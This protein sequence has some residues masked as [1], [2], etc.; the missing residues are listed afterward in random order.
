M[1]YCNTLHGLHM[2]KL[3]FKSNSW[4]PIYLFMSFVIIMSGFFSRMLITLRIMFLSRLNKVYKT[5]TRT[6]Q[7]EL[8]NLQLI[9]QEKRT[10][11]KQIW[12]QLTSWMFNLAG[13]QQS[14]WN[15][16]RHAMEIVSYEGF[17]LN[18]YLH[19]NDII[20]HSNSLLGCNFCSCSIV[21][22]I[23]IQC[24]G[25][26]NHFPFIPSMGQEESLPGA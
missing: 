12:C 2:L 24:G 23:Q 19:N 20:T 5:S 15:Y 16:W 1:Q 6:F 3:K 9:C 21:T 22:A 7:K 17:P 13:L 18:C 25:Q 8:P 14:Q 11:V 26:I 10:V 4:S